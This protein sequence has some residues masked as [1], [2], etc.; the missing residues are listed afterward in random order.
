MSLIRLSRIGRSFCHP[1]PLH[2]SSLL[3]RPAA[4]YS[5]RAC[6]DVS[7]ACGAFP[8]C[9]VSCASRSS[10]GPRVPMTS[11]HSLTMMVVVIGFGFSLTPCSAQDF[12]HVPGWAN[13]HNHRYKGKS[14]GEWEAKTELFAKLAGTGPA[15]RCALRNLSEADGNVIV[16]RYRSQARKTSEPA[17]LRWAQ[18]Q[19]ADHHRQ[20]R[21][22][23]KC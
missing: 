13:T 19:V 10:R 18:G 1:T 17:A 9:R 20:L 6:H 23:G 21:A 3:C 12:N 8:S 15:A 7:R 5:C 11:R 4:I 16:N 22:Q 14:G 2:L